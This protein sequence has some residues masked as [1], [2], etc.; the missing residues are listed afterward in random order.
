MVLVE[1]EREVFDDG[2]APRP[3]GQCLHDKGRRQR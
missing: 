3:L 1:P 2:N